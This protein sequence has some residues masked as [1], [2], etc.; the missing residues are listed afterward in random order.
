MN[1]WSKSSKE[2]L[3]TCHGDLQ[4]LANFVLSV[5]DCTVVWGTRTQEQQDK[6]VL[7]GKSKLNYPNSKHNTYPSLAI[8]LAPYVPSLSGVTW[9][10]EYSL[11]FA[12]I[13]LGCADTLYKKGIINNMVRWGGNWST[14]RDKSFKQISFY[15]GLHFELVMG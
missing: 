9:D 10:R 1:K 6:L 13:V 8:D 14:V 5:H 12:G 3:K 15:D 2:K 11:Y 7:E 4:T